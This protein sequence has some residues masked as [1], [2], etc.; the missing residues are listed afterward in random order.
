VEIS[1]D[2]DHTASVPE[3]RAAYSGYFTP[4]TVKSN[5]AEWLF[6]A[7]LG[8]QEWISKGGGHCYFSRHWSSP[9]Q[10]G[11]HINLLVC[12]NSF[13]CTPVV[14]FHHFVSIFCTIVLKITH[15][16]GVKITLLYFLPGENI[17]I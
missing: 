4:R 9:R 10:K 6:G 3:L 15:N 16:V 1:D 2:D 7:S 11:L 12:K 8:T 13:Q 14:T 5:F 17:K